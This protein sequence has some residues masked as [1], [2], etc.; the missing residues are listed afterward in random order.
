MPEKT[1][2]VC[3]WQLSIQ[4]DK[5]PAGCPGTTTRPD[6]PSGIEDLENVHQPNQVWSHPHYT[7]KS[8]SQHYLTHPW[9]PTTI[10]EAG[11][12][13]G[14]ILS[15]KLSWT[16]HIEMVNK[17]WTAHWLFSVGSFPDVQEMSRPDATKALFA[18]TSNTLALH[19]TP[20]PWATYSNWKH[21]KGGPSVSAVETRHIAWHTCLLVQVNFWIE[22]QKNKS[23]LN[24]NK[25]IK[26]WM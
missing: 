15:D 17:R 16:P 23:L 26:M 1:S 19:G 20:T 9:P 6:Q 10:S 25:A 14:V 22:S 2:S 13:P 7:E 11:E 3:W 12:V 21:Y 5:E 24:A 8:S 18:P 4:E